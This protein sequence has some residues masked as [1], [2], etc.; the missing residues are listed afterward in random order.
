MPVLLVFV[1]CNV[2]SCV[3]IKKNEKAGA[4]LIQL[5]IIIIITFFLYLLNLFLI[6]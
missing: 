3:T 6:K 2:T 5:N 4:P 1:L